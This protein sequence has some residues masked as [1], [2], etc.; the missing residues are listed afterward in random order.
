[1]DGWGGLPEGRVIDAEP[2]LMPGAQAIWEAWQSL[3]WSREVGM[4]V[5]AIA[6][7]EVLAYCEL[8]GVTNLDYR[9]QLLRLLQRLDMTFLKHLSDEEKKRK[10][11]KEA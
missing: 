7:S 6:V 9:A 1:M 11:R 2:E 4:G 8:G 5:G 3:Q 10:D